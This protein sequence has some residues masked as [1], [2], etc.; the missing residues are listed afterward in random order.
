[1]KGVPESMAGYWG[2]N[3]SVID[4]RLAEQNGKW[5]VVDGKAALRPIYDAEKKK[6]PLKTIRKLQHYLKKPTKQPVNLCHNRLVK[7]QIIC[8]AT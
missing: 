3:L 4:L 2:N 6:Q 1:M 7:P 5:A 8:I